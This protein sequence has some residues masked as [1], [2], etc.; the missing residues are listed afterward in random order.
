MSFSV[1]ITVQRGDDL[2]QIPQRILDQ[3]NSSPG[4]GMKSVAQHQVE[5][6]TAKEAEQMLLEAAIGVCDSAVFTGTSWERV[7]VS[8]SGHANPG[9]V[10]KEGWAN[11]YVATTV[12]VLAYT[13]G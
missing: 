5:N 4:E 2:E 3:Y 7:S 9:G 8:I 1:G 11:D 6:G 10:A 12:S 13:E